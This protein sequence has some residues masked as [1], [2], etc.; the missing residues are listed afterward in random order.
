MADDFQNYVPGLESPGVEVERADFSTSDHT[1][2]S[3]P[4]AIFCSADGSLKVDT[5]KVT[6]ATIQVS[7]GIN[8]FRVTKIYQVG[9]DALTVDGW[10]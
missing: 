6:G 10:W 1:F 4:R 3:T 7:K 8:S 2:A 9:S 5:P